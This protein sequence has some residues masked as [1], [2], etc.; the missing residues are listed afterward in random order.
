MMQVEVEFLMEL[1]E[2][3]LRDEMGSL[4]RSAFQQLFHFLQLLH[5]L[6]TQR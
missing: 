1:F 4:L 2:R 6:D 5:L 3:R